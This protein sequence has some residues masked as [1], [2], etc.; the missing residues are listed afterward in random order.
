MLPCRYWFSDTEAATA[1]EVAVFS[2]ETTAQN[3]L[4]ELCHWLFAL[5]SNDKKITT[6]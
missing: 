5:Q 2:W 1:E 6:H 4:L 3:L